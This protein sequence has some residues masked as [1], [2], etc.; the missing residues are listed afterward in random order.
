MAAEAT[1]GRFRPASPAIAGSLSL[2]A[3]G[4]AVAMFGALTSAASPPGGRGRIIL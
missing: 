2:E 3:A 4:L 1:A